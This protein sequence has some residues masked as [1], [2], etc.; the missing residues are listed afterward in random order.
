MG[1]INSKHSKIL[2]AFG[3]VFLSILVMFGTIGSPV[4]YNQNEFS[5]SNIQNLEKSSLEVNLA[6]IINKHS[7]KTTW[8]QAQKRHPKLSTW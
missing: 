4:K 2:A 3:M 1:K 6:K 8:N 5:N 7:K